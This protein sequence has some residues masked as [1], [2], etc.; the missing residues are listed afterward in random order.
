M[1]T[2]QLF[3]PGV[4]VTLSSCAAGFKSRH[5][6]TCLMSI[7]R[8]S[9]ECAVWLQGA[10]DIQTYCLGHTAFVT[11]VSFVR[12]DSGATAIVTAS[13]DGSVRSATAP[14]LGRCRAVCSQS[15]TCPSGLSKADHMMVSA[16]CGTTRQANSWQM[17]S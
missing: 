11:A 9:C 5:V 4:I 10:H 7:G 13:G 1:S 8:S 16:G 3:Q 14:G 15:G 12:A 17:S 2:L 6:R